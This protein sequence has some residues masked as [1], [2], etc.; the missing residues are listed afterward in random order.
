MRRLLFTETNLQNLPAPPA[1]YRYIGFDGPT[2]SIQE[3]GGIESIGLQGPQGPIGP[4]GSGGGSSLIEVSYLEI[5]TL[6]E[7]NSLEVANYYLITDFKTCY[8]Q[9]DY[10]IYGNAIT[11][12]N[13]KVGST[14]SII[15]FA[16]GTSS[17]SI[18]AWQPDFPKDKIKYDVSWT[19]S[20]HTGGTAYGRITERIDEWNN[21]TDYDHRE[22]YFKRYDYYLY[23]I[24]N[25]QVGT[26][27]SVV[28]G[29]VT[30]VDTLFTNFS[31][32]DVIALPNFSEEVFKIDTIMSA[33]AMSL[34]GSVWDVT[35]FGEMKYYSVNYI[36]NMCSPKK[37]NVSDEFWNIR[38]FDNVTAFNNY[39]GDQANS[40][41]MDGIGDFIL[42]N[43]VFL[44]G[45]YYN[46]RFGNNCFN[47][48]FDDDCTNNTIGNF[49]CDNITDDDFDQ[50][51]I[52]NYFQRN[53]ITANFQRNSVGEDFNDNIITVGSFYRNK[54]NNQFEYNKISGQDFQN[55][56]IGNAFN[57]NII[58]T[59]FDG[60]L[61]N[62]IGVGFN[63]NEIRGEF[64]SNTFGNGSNGNKFYSTLRD[65]KIGDYFID[66][67]IGL[68]TNYG[69]NIFYENHI[70]NNF[71]NNN[72]YREFYQNR[73]FNDFFSNDVYNYFYRNEIGYNFNDNVVGDYQNYG[74]SDFKQNIC[75][76]YVKGN[77][78]FGY[79][80]GNEFGE[81]FTGNILGDNIHRNIFGWEA[82][83]N[84][85]GNDFEKN[86]IGSYFSENNIGNGFSSNTI[87]SNFYNNN[88]SN[89]FA[90]NKIGE[91]FNNNSIENDFGFGGGQS[92][93]NKI[94]NY[95]ENNQ[96]GEYFY[97][98]M[99]NDLFS[100]NSVGHHF[101]FNDVKIHYLYNQNL[102]QG[103]NEIIS[104]T[105]N[106]GA[107]PSIPGTD[108]V[109]IGLTCVS[110]NDGVD[111]T[112]DVTVA[113]SVVT[114]VSL[115]F[116]GYGY[117]IGSEL[118]IPY[119][120]FGGTDGFD[121]II[122][123]AS[124][125]TTPPIY[126]NYNSTVFENSNN[127]YRVSHYDNNDVLTITDL[128]PAP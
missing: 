89:D 52:G 66:N 24:N 97:S 57:Y 118:T 70:G 106:T 68:V 30:G 128:V 9:P 27:S 54:I 15:V 99:V 93:G 7:S 8:D 119:Q 48:T 12:G 88:I 51:Q 1:G 14:H 53:I 90:Y 20:E 44:D 35:S 126:G 125:S 98:N 46:N 65:N 100:S 121:I 47:N 96:I 82:F 2:F 85:I 120:K 110:V 75:K 69:E 67:V 19:Q 87:G 60:F 86:T 33:T 36:M 16:T 26:I 4:T 55:N 17:L 117:D 63:G 108:G 50:N 123:V 115:N 84:N 73:I 114:N 25:P 71:E 107:S 5:R 56:I 92:Y 127:E 76:S 21:R 34:T 103:Y 77:L 37:S 42:S 6:I 116:H 74:Y 58:D 32:G 62:I 61:K 80:T 10:D 29:V 109:Y 111:A 79:T 22:V 18:D 11:S 28:N 59:L 94:G 112:F 102:Q 124:V 45:P 95:F 31:V 49:F 91:H 38:T 78:F 83:Q 105:D 122:T 81:N 43:N 3:E 13:Y 101:R 104:F 72:I 41:I 64:E 40:Y 113:S 39:I 23:D